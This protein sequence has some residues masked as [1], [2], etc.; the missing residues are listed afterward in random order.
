MSTA[1]EHIAGLERELTAT[2]EMLAFVLKAV[3]E[4]VTVT[5]EMVKDGLKNKEIRIDEDLTDEA[6][7][8]SLRDAS[9]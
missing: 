9:E 3:G 8:F 6:F 1:D 4:P 7:I 5:K 2:Q